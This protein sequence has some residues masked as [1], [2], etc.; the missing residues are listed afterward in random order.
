M[1]HSMHDDDVGVDKTN[2]HRQAGVRLDSDTSWAVQL[3]RLLLSVSVAFGLE[4]C[5]DQSAD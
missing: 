5:G 1:T 3:C 2:A 4:R